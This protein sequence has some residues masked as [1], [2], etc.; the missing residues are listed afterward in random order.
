MKYRIVKKTM[1]NGS[2]KFWIQKR[3]LFFWINIDEM[4][5]FGYYKYVCFTQLRDAE[6][7]VKSL[8]Q[9]DNSIYGSKVIKKEI[10]K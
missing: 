9:I 8:Y 7:Y 4:I 6:E 2:S 1:R 3:F 10:I 5:S